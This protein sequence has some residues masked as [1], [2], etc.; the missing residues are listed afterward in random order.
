MSPPHSEAV[1]DVRE[2]DVDRYAEAGWVKV[3]SEPKKAPAKKAA[4][5]KSSK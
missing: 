4:S 2:D 1:A 5:K 3:K